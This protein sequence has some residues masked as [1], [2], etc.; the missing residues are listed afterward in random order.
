MEHIPDDPIGSWLILARAAGLRKTTR[1]QT[2]KVED[3]G[4]D[5]FDREVPD[6]EIYRELF[7]K[8]DYPQTL[9]AMCNKYPVHYAQVGAKSTENSVHIVAWEKAA[10]GRLVQSLIEKEVPVS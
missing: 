10:K 6:K 4:F 8:V 7:K 2:L 1:V 9:T 5:P 3:C